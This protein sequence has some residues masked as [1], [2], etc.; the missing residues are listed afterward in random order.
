MVLNRLIDTPCLKELSELQSYV[1]GLM[2]SDS[3]VAFSAELTKRQ[4]KDSLTAA[5]LQDKISSSS[6]FSALVNNEAWRELSAELLCTEKEDIDIVFPH[7]RIDLPARFLSDKK[8]M[9]LPWHQEAGYYLEKGGC[10]P[11]SIVL[12]THLHSCD[13]EG[14]AIWIGKDSCD[15]LL[16]H[17]K[18]FMD[19]DSSR[20]LRVTC[21]APEAFIKAES[22]FG[23]TIAFDFMRPHRSGINNS[24][25][26]RLTF[27]LRA[28]SRS[29]LSRWRS[30]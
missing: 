27:L 19:E 22:K 17:Q 1:F 12:S 4:E 28:T 11:N 15:S 26:V 25:L 29:D 14:G 18:Q 2:G 20:F 24:S 8:K 10:T 5:Q 16:E 13:S 7:F 3:H 21:S 30:L 23:E 6:E 9:S